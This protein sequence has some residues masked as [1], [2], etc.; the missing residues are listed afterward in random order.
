[1]VKKGISSLE[2][3]ALVQELQFIT[4]GKIDQIYHQQEKE[5]LLQVHVPR[6]GKVLV[7]I[8]PGKFLCQ[9]TKKEVLLKPSSFCMQLRKYL[10]NA[11]IKQFYQKGS[12][13]IMVLEL[14]KKET[15]FLI[16]ELF[17]KGNII[18]TNEKYNIIGVL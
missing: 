18:L 6:H 17:S 12:E 7:R 15:F 13:R 11:N 16:I 5:L 1:M 4:G 14:E 2:L 9:T 3:T 10:D 8:V